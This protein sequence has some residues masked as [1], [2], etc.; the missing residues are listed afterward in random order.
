MEYIGLRLIAYQVI[1]LIIGAMYFVLRRDLRERLIAK[2]C[3]Q[4][5]GRPFFRTTQPQAEASRP[6]PL[7]GCG[8]QSCFRHF[9]HASSIHIFL[10]A[11]GSQ[12]FKKRCVKC[13]ART[14]ILRKRAFLR[15]RSAENRR[16]YSTFRNT[17]CIN[18]IAWT[19]SALITRWWWKRQRPGFLLWPI[20]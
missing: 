16:T 20:I 14:D 6:N 4:P 3:Q 17:L 18:R 9:N 12:G 13:R 8:V 2:T 1:A 15:S 10:E 5:S 11:V 19:V 7:C